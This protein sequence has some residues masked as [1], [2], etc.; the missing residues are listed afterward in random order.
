MP[1]NE[2]EQLVFPG[3]EVEW[4]TDAPAHTT[5]P[6]DVMLRARSSSDAQ[7][8]PDEI[9]RPVDTERKHAENDAN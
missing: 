7:A 9:H 2:S 1:H 4:V 6:D 3:V 5:V 8:E